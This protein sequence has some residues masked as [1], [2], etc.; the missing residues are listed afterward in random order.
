MAGEPAQGWRQPA[1]PL[2]RWRR[3]GRMSC[4][5]SPASATGLRVSSATRWCQFGATAGLLERVPSCLKRLTSPTVRWNS[6]VRLGGITE[7]ALRRGLD[8]ELPPPPPAV[9][10]ALRRKGDKV[11]PGRRYLGGRPSSR[12]CQA[13]VR[14]RCDLAEWEVLGEAG[15]RS[16]HL[17]GLFQDLLRA[18]RRRACRRAPC[19]APGC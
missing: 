18:C 15:V 14:L 5:R 19:R 3:S 11:P 16:A 1:A 4:P 2:A 7:C 6:T 12:A 9:H 8:A 17:D 10:W 13:P